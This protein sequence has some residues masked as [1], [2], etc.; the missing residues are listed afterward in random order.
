[1]I[2]PMARS[3]TPRPPYLKV[4][5]SDIAQLSRFLVHPFEH[6]THLDDLRYEIG[7]MTTRTYVSLKAGLTPIARKK[8]QKT[9]A[10]NQHHPA[11]IL[12]NQTVTTKYCS[13]W[14]GSY[15]EKGGG[16]ISPTS[17]RTLRSPTRGAVRERVLIKMMSPVIPCR[18][19]YRMC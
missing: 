15:T 13:V 3:P 11:Q 18:L 10:A 9:P 14:T 6:Y 5:P 4:S 17:A 12:S 8:I 2:H 7:D 19:Q 16:G 1:M